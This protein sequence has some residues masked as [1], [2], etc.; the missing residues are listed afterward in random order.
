MPGFYGVDCAHCGKP[1]FLSSYEQ[2]RPDVE[3][4]RSGIGC[5]YCGRA[6]IYTQD[7]L[8]FYERLTEV[9]PNETEHSDRG[10]R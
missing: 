2:T 6:C 9:R 10:K 1:I 4:P 7:R 5:P 3:M 8:L